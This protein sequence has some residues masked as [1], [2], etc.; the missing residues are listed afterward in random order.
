MSKIRIRKIADFNDAK[1]YLERINS[2]IDLRLSHMPPDTVAGV[3]NTMKRDI[4]TDLDTWLEP[5][6]CGYWFTNDLEEFRKSFEY[7][8]PIFENTDV[9]LY[10]CYVTLDDEFSTPPRVF[11]V[12]YIT[13]VNDVT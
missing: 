2:H 3:L 10:R 1:V 12:I 5:E 13:D 6:A 11:Y 8:T 7:V 4:K 9:A